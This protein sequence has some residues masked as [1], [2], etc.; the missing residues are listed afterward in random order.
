MM[1]SNK[2]YLKPSQ[3]A[4][5]VF[6][7]G[8]LVTSLIL[9]IWFKPPFQLSFF[10]VLGYFLLDLYF[11]CYLGK[12]PIKV[13]LGDSFLFSLWLIMFYWIK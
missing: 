12:V 4:Y 11:L 13:I 2:Y 10:L 8:L 3:Q 6:Y 7:L 1:W 5:Y 9:L